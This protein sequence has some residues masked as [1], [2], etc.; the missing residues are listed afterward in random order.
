MMLK[1]SVINRE[2]RS[3]QNKIFSPPQSIYTKKANK[4]GSEQK[5]SEVLEMRG[6][7]KISLNIQKQGKGATFLEMP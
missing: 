5:D 7:P 2:Y 1:G 4:K 3:K 6:S